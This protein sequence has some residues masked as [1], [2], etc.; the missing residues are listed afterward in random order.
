M[1]NVFLELIL[2]L[3]KKKMAWHKVRKLFNE[4][5]LW[6]GI[7]SGI[8]IFLVC[9]S[10]TLYTFH[11]E[12]EEWLAP[13]RF[14]VDVPEKAEKLAAEELIGQLENSTGGKVQSITIPADQKRAYLF[15][16]KK[17]GEKGRGDNYLV[18]PYTAEVTGSGGGPGSQFF[19]TMFRL[20]RWLLLDSK[21][22][23]PIVGTATIIFFFIILSGLI[24]WF[25]Q[26]IK[27]WKQGLKIKFSANW[28]R[29]NHDL[30]NTLGFYASIFLLVMV[31]T[32]LCWSFDWY[33]KGLSKVLGAEVFGGRNEQPMESKI[34]VEG[35]SAYPLPVAD[36]IEKANEVLPYQGDVRISMPDTTTASVTISKN[37]TGF[38]SVSAPDKIQLDQYSG[39]VLKVEKFSNK[40]LN[41]QIASSIKP[42]HTGEFFGT[43][44]K[45]LYFITCLIATSLPITGTIIWINKLKKKAKKAGK[46][47]LRREPSLTESIG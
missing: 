33:K 34:P 41:Q 26:K 44:S 11:H 31:L 46:P 16:I 20:H 10:G 1:G 4:I 21:I 12:V 7:G 30:H 32:G 14:Y 36:F 5:H 9:L 22:G 39:E 18:N 47:A 24:I 15:N 42:L 40:P 35:F 27:S 23:R 3:K 25:P 38:F 45:I 13:E 28:K 29:I 19:M 6:L 17:E 43:F 8:I 37:Q 2:S